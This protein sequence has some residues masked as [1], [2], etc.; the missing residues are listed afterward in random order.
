MAAQ[1][2]LFS[3]GVDCSCH[4][5]M[6]PWTTSCASGTAGMMLASIPSSLRTYFTVYLIALIARRRLPS[7]KDLK[8]T[9]AGILQSAAFLSTN[10]WCFSLFVCLLRQAL[11]RFYFG[12]AALV[13][14]FFASIVALNVE[15]PA[16][17]AA[18][19]LYVTNVGLETLWRMLEARGLVHSIPNAQVL[20]MG[21]S[22][23]ALL[24]LQRLGL[25]RTVA[26]DITFKV[27]RVIIGKE[28]EGPLNMPVAN[29]SGSLSSRQ[30]RLSFRSIR[31]ILGLYE[32]FRA[33]K[34]S[35]CPHRQGCA[36]YALRG[37]LKPFVGGVGL[38][39]S[40]KLLLNISKIVRL[41]MDWRKR[42]F[43]K[44]SLKLGLALGSFSLLYKMTSCALRHGFGYDN[45]LFAIPAG[46]LGSIGLLQ[47]PNT[48]VS[49]YI[50]LKLLH[51]LYNWGIEGGVLPEVPHFITY[52]YA[53][54]TAILFHSSI[55]EPR[56]LR[57]S[58]YRFLMN[59][60]GNRICRFGVRSLEDLGLESHEQ[61]LDVVQKLKINTASPNPSVP[62]M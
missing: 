3:A 34:H 35:S 23:T 18:L 58:Y 38:T 7:L 60:S 61:M 48:T 33:A 4:A 55:L 47:F 12:T 11:G 5:Y 46:L 20:I 30:R 26:K 36:I 41:K 22:I 6:H 13:P 32:H 59:M 24:Y 14:A 62:L 56:S 45:A 2:K 16:R 28:E 8:H 17:R 52:L 9:G 44:D 19:A 1:S 42:M 49:L 21:P 50:M 25:H 31:T 37:G 15:R 43:N 51:L 57:D 29:S 39:L 54:F 53:F 27:L 10:A 40:L